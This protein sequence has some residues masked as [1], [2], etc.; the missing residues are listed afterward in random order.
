MSL[1]KEIK[2]LCRQYSVRP[3]RRRG[4]NFL[5]NNLVIK[6]VLEPADLK[7]QDVVLEIGAGLGTLTKEI[8][9]KVKKVIAV[10]I[11]KELVKAL[12][13]ELK[14]YKNVEIVQED[15]RN[16]RLIVKLLNCYPE[17]KVVANLPFNITGLVL[18]R[19][20]AGE[21]KPQSMVLILQKEVGE[22][23]VARPPKMSRLALTVQFYSQAKIMAQVKKDNFWPKPKVD[24]TI[25]RIVPTNYESG[26]NINEDRFFQIIRAGFSSPRKYLLNNLAKSGII[27]N[28]G[29]L[30][31]GNIGTSIQKRE[32]MKI[33]KQIGLNP[34]V[35]AQELSVEEWIRLVKKIE[36]RC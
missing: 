18:R 32:I 36:D 34:K 23:I 11:D 16:D 13:N 35:R 20:L 2:T 29:T 22:R 4:Q 6:K 21:N 1:L 9:R 15:I 25:L 27:K 14:S 17:Y 10:E 30:E 28:M 24:S 33:F 5:I 3:L 26:A 8:A 7:K 19:F 12:K 31:H